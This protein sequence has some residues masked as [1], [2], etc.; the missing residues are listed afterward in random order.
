MVYLIFDA[1]LLAKAS[2]R[3]ETLGFALVDPRYK[4]DKTC[5]E[6]VSL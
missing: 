3:P 4:L 5:S 1:I 6:Y 2:F